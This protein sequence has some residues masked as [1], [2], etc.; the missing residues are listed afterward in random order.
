MKNQAIIPVAIAILVLVVAGLY[1][2]TPQVGPQEQPLQLYQET[3]FHIDENGNAIG[4][5]IYE[6]PPSNFA[7]Y[8]RLGIVGGTLGGA[9]VRGIGVE[10]AKLLYIAS[11]RSDYAKYGLELENISCDI[12]G[13]NTGETFKIIIVWKTPYLAYRHENKWRVSLQPVDNESF[14]RNYINDVKTFQSTLS[15]ISQVYGENCQPNLISKTSFI[16]PSGAN[17]ANENELLSLGTQSIDY[18]GGTS[19]N[20][21]TYIRENEGKPA[22]VTEGQAMI[23]VQLITITEEEFLEAAQFCPI[24]YTEVPS[25]HGFEGSA[26]WATLDMKF[27]RER[28]EYSISFDGVEFNVTPSQLLYYSAREV[29]ILAENSDENILSDA[30]PISVL[31]PDNESGVWSENIW[32]PFANDNYIALA[33]GVR[34]QIASTGEAP[35]TINSSIGEFRSKDALFTFLRI[36]SFHYNHGGL[37]DNILFAPAPMGNLT[38]DNAEI[39]ANLAYFLLS[40]QYAVT[41]TSRAS[42]IVSDIREPDYDDSELAEGLCEWVYENITYTLVLGRFTSEEVLDM[43]EGKCLDKATLYL[44][45]ARTADMPAREVTGFLIFES[46]TPPFVEIAGITPD[47]RYIVGHAWT[48]VFL[49]SQGWVFADPT[50]G[51]FRMFL[52]GDK[53]YSRVEETWQDVLASHESTYG[54]LI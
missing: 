45:L 9:P 27:G 24:D 6:I 52:Y 28:E 31:P 46:L 36:I 53:I 47:G 22:V 7:D 8:N 23:T 15:V 33:R 35:G 29:V 51:Y 20:S 26:A 17:I 32:K 54:K 50:G 5:F 4:E 25:A 41:D 44:A 34:D 11:T 13:L 3:I 18:G 43:R 37:P 40:T 14:A 30:Q 48:E 19:E 10:N 1:L 2:L 21:A 39:P 49:P 42:Q 38:R 16:L 12:T